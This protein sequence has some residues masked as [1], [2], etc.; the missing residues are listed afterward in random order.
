MAGLCGSSGDTDSPMI[1]STPHCLLCETKSRAHSAFLLEGAWLGFDVE[2]LADAIDDA[3][4]ELLSSDESI[5]QA[6]LSVFSVL[7]EFA[8]WP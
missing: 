4:L 6:V 5:G 8:H 2:K 1:R 7:E 3:C